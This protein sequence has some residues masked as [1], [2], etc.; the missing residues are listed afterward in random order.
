M[1]ELSKSIHRCSD[2]VAGVLDAVHELLAERIRELEIDG[3][4][5]AAP[6]Q[7]TIADGIALLGNFERLDELREMADRISLFAFKRFGH[8]TAS[9]NPPAAEVPQ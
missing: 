8:E 7:L 4:A 2:D 6:R 5:T 3:A 1:S 9:A